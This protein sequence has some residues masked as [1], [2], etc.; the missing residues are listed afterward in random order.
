M[1]MSDDFARLHR[2]V[3]GPPPQAAQELAELWREVFGQPPPLRDEPELLSRIL[4]QNLPPAP[5]YRPGLPAPCGP[6]AA[7]ARTEA[8]KAE[9]PSQPVRGK[10]R[11]R[12]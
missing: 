2:M 7:P 12:G 8:V 11:R 3:F 4:V 1:Y 10:R 6:S 9:E 5:P